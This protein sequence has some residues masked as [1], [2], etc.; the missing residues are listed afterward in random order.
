MVLPPDV[1]EDSARGKIAHVQS[2]LKHPYHD[3]SHPAHRDAVAEVTDLY[4][5]AYPSAPEGE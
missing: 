4:D 2:D 3:R 1:A 5:V